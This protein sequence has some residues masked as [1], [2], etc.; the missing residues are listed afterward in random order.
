MDEG[1]LLAISEH[2][3]V[4]AE[5]MLEYTMSEALKEHRILATASSKQTKSKSV[6]F[7]RLEES[8]DVTKVLQYVQQ[9]KLF[10]V[11]FFHAGNL[12]LEEGNK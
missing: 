7:E 6:Q 3:L 1:I 8:A 10:R 11:T 12:L 9:G 4:Q 2:L 5:E